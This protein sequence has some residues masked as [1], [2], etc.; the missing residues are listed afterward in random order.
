MLG[1]SLWPLDSVMSDSI[2]MCRYILMML[3]VSS[4]SCDMVDHISCMRHRSHTCHGVGVH[5]GT[6][7]CRGIRNWM[8]SN[9]EVSMG[10]AGCLQVLVVGFLW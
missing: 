3:M 5:V 1:S 10:L 8:K 6:C 9:C 2:N 7:L 4:C